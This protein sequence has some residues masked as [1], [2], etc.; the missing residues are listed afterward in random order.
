MAVS[1]PLSFVPPPDPDIVRLHV[2]ESNNPV[3]GF[4]EI[5][6]VLT[7]TYPNY[8]TRYVTALANSVD[9]WFAIQWEDASGARSAL[10]AP[11]KGGTTTLIGELIERVMLRSSTLDENVVLQE[12]EA[13]VSF[14]YKVDDPYS[15]NI[16][17]VNSL[18]LTELTTL[19]LAASLYVTTTIQGATTQDYTAGLIS[20]RNSID[21][22]SVQEN[23]ERL[24]RRALR[25]LG[26]GGSLIASIADSKYLVSVTGV[27]TSFDSSRLLSARATLTDQFVIRD[28]VTGEL[29]S[30][31]SDAC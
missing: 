2:F 11:I 3:S 4:T 9:D 5:D 25:R 28:V 16:A 6:S 23:L 22:R 29:I 31:T 19:V 1:V 14:I 10:S 20:E 12:A 21:T 8:I 18:W 24:E 26:I 13:V 30:P 15:V 17:S 7:G 27:K